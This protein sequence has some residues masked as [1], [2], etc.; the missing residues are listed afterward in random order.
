MLF[1]IIYYLEHTFYYNVSYLYVNA[2]FGGDAVEDAG[3]DGEDDVREPEGYEWRE[4]SGMDEHLAE[5]EEEDVGE[6]KADTYTDIPSDTA[7]SLLRRQGDTHDGQN[8]C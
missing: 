2:L 4:G 8:E 7:S 3:D 1:G 6:G 5:A